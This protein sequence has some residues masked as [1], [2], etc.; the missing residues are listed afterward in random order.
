[1]GG[2]LLLIGWR[3]APKLPRALVRGL[4]RLAAWVTW[5]I[6]PGGVKQLEANLARVA[7]S[8]RWQLRLLSLRALESYLRY[9]A[10][11]LT[12]ASCTQSQ[13]DARVRVEGP[14]RAMEAI[15]A[16]GAAVLALGHLGNYD[17]GGAW[18]SRHL[19]PLVTVAERLQPTQL[20]DE[21][22]TFREHLGMKIYAHKGEDA[23]RN[24]VRHAQGGDACIALLGDRDLSGSGIEVQMFGQTVP[25]A[26]GPATISAAT[27]VPVIPTTIHYERLHGQRRRQARWPW[28]IVITFGSPLRVDRSAP[29]TGELTRVSQEWINTVAAGIQAHPQDWHMMQKLFVADLDQSRYQAKKAA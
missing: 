21:F 14:N 10:E 12:L 27:G 6:R 13:I 9:W 16:E 24:L 4:A 26:A 25:V 22:R 28:G 5:L 11:V 7:V 29:R 18:A 3:V 19:A 17:L 20:F 1:M 8:S 2:R 23:F 15:S